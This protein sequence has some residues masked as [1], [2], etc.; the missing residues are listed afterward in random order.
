M[1]GAGVRR[2][3]SWPCPT[4]AP[5]VGLARPCHYPAPGLGGQ[6]PSSRI[7]CWPRSSSTPDAICQVVGVDATL[8]PPRPPMESGSYGRSS[9]L[10][11]VAFLA[12]LAAYVSGAGEIDAG[13]HRHT[14]RAR[15][16]D[17]ASTSSRPGSSSMASPGSGAAPS[18]SVRRCWRLIGRRPGN[19]GRRRGSP[20]PR[21]APPTPATATGSGWRSAAWSCTRYW[22]LLQRAPGRASAVGTDHRA[23]VSPMSAGLAING[24]LTTIVRRRCARYLPA[25]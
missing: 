3:E 16:R 18:A 9:A 14:I 24:V 17:A 2:R 21:C 12:N 22:T 19:R 11:S 1:V 4:L 6:L 10:L 20:I 25:R 23:A 8:C 7:S 13:P 5:R 15:R